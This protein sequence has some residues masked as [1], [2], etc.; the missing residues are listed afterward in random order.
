MQEKAGKMYCAYQ[1]YSKLRT[2]FVNCLYGV[3][4]GLLTARIACSLAAAGRNCLLVGSGQP[5]SLAR[6]QRPAGIACSLAAV[7]RSCLPIVFGR[8]LATA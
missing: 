6:W 3:S 2:S 4:C 1:C 8:S 7:G 5:E